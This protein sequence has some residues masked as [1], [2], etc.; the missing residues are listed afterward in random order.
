[1]SER[2]EFIKTLKSIFDAA[3]KALREESGEFLESQFHCDF[4][5]ALIDVGKEKI[6]ELKEE[7]YPY[8]KDTNSEYRAE[9]IRTLGWG[10]RLLDPDFKSSVHDIWLHDPDEEVKIAA[11]ASWTDYYRYS[12]DPKILLEL[13]HILISQ[14]YSIEI[15]TCVLDG[16]FEVAGAYEV[17]VHGI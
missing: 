12:E 5:D 13:Y 17:I 10:T 11:L 3:K 7:V 14:D 15:K 16:M 6:Y 9:A 8:V 1:M 4:I 2:N